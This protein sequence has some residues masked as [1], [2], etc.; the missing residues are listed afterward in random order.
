M[1][2]SFKTKGNDQDPEEKSRIEMAIPAH[3]FSFLPSV[4][5]GLNTI[6][7]PDG[8]VYTGHVK[9]GRKHGRGIIKFITGDVYDGQFEEDLYCGLGTLMLKDSTRYEGSFLGGFYDGT[10]IFKYVE[11]VSHDHSLFQM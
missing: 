10:V 5:D 7:F 6:D 9:D 8:S 4:P 11:R 3:I 1:S 2:F